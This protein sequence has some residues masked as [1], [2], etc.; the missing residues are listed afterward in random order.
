MSSKGFS[1]Q[2]HDHEVFPFHRRI[3]HSARLDGDPSPCPIDGAGVAPSQN[4]QPAAFQTEVRFMDFAQQIPRSSVSRS[5]SFVGL[6][7]FV[8]PPRFRH[9]GQNPSSG[10]FDGPLCVGVPFAPHLDEQ[11]A[12]VIKGFQRPKDALKIDASLA[13]RDVPELSRKIPL[14]R[15][16]V[17]QVNGDGL[18]NA[19]LQFLGDVRGSTR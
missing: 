11:G 5:F 17:F 9:F 3:G 19:Q 14:D 18:K 12:P 13:E 2:I 7:S 16:R 10:F 1:V 8:D 15:Q 4:R 6:R